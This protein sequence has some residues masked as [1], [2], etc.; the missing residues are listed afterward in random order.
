MPKKDIFVDANVAKNFCN[1]ADEVYKEFIRWLFFQ[2]SL[3]VS[4]KLLAEY[5][6]GC[7]GAQSDSNVFAIIAAQLRKGRLAKFEN[8]QLRAVKFSKSQI[9][10][11][12]SNAADHDHL[13]LVILSNRRL[14]IT[15]DKNLRDD[16]NAFPAIGARAA[17]RP[18]EIHYRTGGHRS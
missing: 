6:R 9:K 13:R 2:G 14:A 11:L 18:D 7:G 15:I 10:K 3:A 5:N 1:P 8:E 4:N 12:L 16:I 17:A